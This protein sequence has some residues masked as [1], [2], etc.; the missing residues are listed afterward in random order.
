MSAEVNKVIT[1]KYD[2]VGEAMIYGD[3]DSCYF[4][5]YPTL[6]NDIENKKIPWSKDN[7][8][9]LYDQVCE[10]ANLSLIHI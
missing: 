8:I 10:A 1:G 6:K 7:V 4:S 3:T 5:A 9:T 2:H